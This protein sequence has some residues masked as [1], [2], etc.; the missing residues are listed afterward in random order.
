MSGTYSN[1]IFSDILQ[2]VEGCDD[3]NAV[4]HDQEKCRDEVYGES[5]TGIVEPCDPFLPGDD[6]FSS[7]DG[8]NITLS[9]LL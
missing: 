8:S 5:N 3:G 7:D 4:D 6:D 9:N 1:I 2:S